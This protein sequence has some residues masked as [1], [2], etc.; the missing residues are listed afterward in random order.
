MPRRITLAMMA[1][2]L[3][4]AAAAPPASALSLTIGTSA[5]FS[6]FRPGQTATGSGSLLA[7]A[8]PPWTLTV[9]D[10]GS[11]AGHMVRAATGCT[12]SDPQLTNALTVTVTGSGTSAG[13]KA[14]GATATTVASGGNI[15]VATVL[16]TNYSQVIPPS[17]TMRTGCVYSLTATYTLQGG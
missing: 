17:Q 15:L 10:L 8:L 2:T 7:T 16:N 13:A 4:L 6:N 11:G 12:D 3:T 9:A 14:I 1:A 5:T